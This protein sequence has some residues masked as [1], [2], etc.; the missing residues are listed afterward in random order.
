M[1]NIKQH[2]ESPF[3]GYQLALPDNHYDYI[4]RHFG[5]SLLQS[6]IS[7]NYTH[8]DLNKQLTIRNWVIELLNKLLE[9]D[10]HYLKEKIAFLWVDIAKRCWGKALRHTKYSKENEL[11]SE[12]ALLES[13]GSFDK[14]LYNLWNLNTSARELSLIIFRTLFEDIYLLEDPIASSRSRELTSLCPEVITS[15]KILN[16]KYEPNEQLSMF[17]N[18]D[19]GWLNIWSSFLAE[20]LDNIEQDSNKNFVIKILQTLKTCLQW[21]L[22]LA[23]RDTRI[24][25]RLSQCFMYDNDVT[26][27]TLATESLHALLTRTFTND[28]DFKEIPGAVF[29]KDGI[30]MLTRVYRSIKLDPNDIDD[31]QYSLTKKMVEMIVG[32]TEYLYDSK[33]S[34]NNFDLPQ[35]SD[36]RGYLNLVLETTNHESLIVSGLSLQFWCTVLRMDEL[37]AKPHF[38]EALSK[39]LEIAANRLINYEDFTDDS[40]VKSFLENDFEE[41]SDA[42]VF[43]SNYRKLMDD[44]VRITICQKPKDG[45]MWLESRLEQFFS[46]DL[47]QRT[48]IDA[49]LQY[50]GENAESYI[51]GY[52]QFVLIEASIR[53][54]SRWQIWYDDTHEDKQEKSDFLHKLVET[55]CER[56]LMLQIKDPLLLRKQVQTLV[57]FAPLLKDKSNNLMFKVLEKVINSCTFEYSES[58][59]DDE[60]ENI[61]D[62]RT[63]CG[64]ELNR[65]LYLMPESL[66]DILNDLEIVISNILSSNKVT[67][68]EAVAFKSFLLVVSQRSTIDNKTDR[69]STI[70]DPE[71]IAWS[72]PKTEKG[73]L[74]L[75]WFMER[76]GIV[77]IAEYFQSRGITA[78]TDLLAADMDDAGRVLKNDLKKHWSSVFPIRAT[79]IFIQYSIEKL[80]HDSEDYLNLLALWKPRI[81]PILPHILQL[82][83]QIQAYHNP[84]NWTD[85][86][87]EV[88][89]F[90]KETCTERFWQQGVSIQ[91]KD[92]FVEESVKAMHTLRD[93]ADS[94]GHIVRYTREYAYLT[95]G[96]ISELEETLYE[97]PNMATKLW[98][99][100]A[101]EPVGISLHSWRHLINLVLRNVIKNCPIRFIEPFMSE[102][103]PQVLSTLDAL[104]IEKWEV[105]YLKGLQLD[106]NEN[107]QTLSEEMMEEHLLRQ[108][109][110]VVD[111]ML[112]DLVG[113]LGHTKLSERQITIREL[114][115]SNPQILGLFLQILNHIILFKDTRCSYNAILVLRNI[116]SDILNKNKEV[117]LWIN[118]NFIKSLVT[119]IKDPFFNDCHSEAGYLLTTIYL[120]L[121][122]NYEFPQKY[123]IQLLDIS[124]LKSIDLL[125]ELLSQSTSIRSQKVVMISFVSNE[126]IFGNAANT[127]SGSGRTKDLE[128]ASRKKKSNGLQEQDYTGVNT[129]FGDD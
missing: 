123:L 93:F 98:R 20:C 94:V 78:S 70:V 36:I 119:I 44:I 121:R 90:V 29:T 109:T 100:I 52:A 127:G 71:L 35:N 46:S 102:L 55:L 40:S 8:Y 114:I 9:K 68:H 103:L 69:F 96:S 88:Q 79:R 10:P 105:T 48:L 97:V 5:L 95:I 85:L 111:R 25:E 13:W 91:S 124:D 128:E 64:T 89:S 84:A 2:E 108:L 112:I 30:D 63:S 14:D 110:A 59:T 113:Q 39:L 34:K 38:Q 51:Y 19:E 115:C 118:D 104:L 47:G 61:R 11:F 56:L 49:H 72:D 62:L 12:D 15:Q 57:Q 60:R 41:N 77:K 24:L 37:S 92:S 1:E 42:L 86:P 76:L 99:A 58:A 54:I 122:K 125:E 33:S 6:T 81:Q 45:L 22:P 28:E 87:I 31:Q 82:I 67:D 18:S 116:I 50:K 83:A 26:I 129:L 4:V 43:L 120:S 21:V 53:G 66:K 7:R 80:P 117:D 73:L 126:A 107:D 101:G 23:I 75:P 3:W 106:G 32:L 17:R 16:I 74:E 65:L 27:R